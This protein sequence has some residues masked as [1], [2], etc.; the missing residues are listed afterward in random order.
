M[1][2]CAGSGMSVAWVVAVKAVGWDG[3]SETSLLV[4]QKRAKR[5]EEE[6]KLC[7]DICKGTRE[8][9]WESDAMRRGC[10]DE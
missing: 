9:G 7:A 1:I 8:G 4:S 3:D 10:G 2:G 5:F 6:A